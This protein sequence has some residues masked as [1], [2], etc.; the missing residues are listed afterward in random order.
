LMFEGGRYDFPRHLGPRG[1]QVFN[2][3]EI[4]RSQ[5]PDVDGNVVPVGITEGSAELMGAQGEVDSM[6]VA[7][8]AGIY[9]VKKGTCNYSCE[10]C[11]GVTDASVTPSSFAIALGSTTQLDFIETWST[12]QQF[13]G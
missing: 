11:T 10:T 8:D 9:N 6:L 7:M 13:H 1:T 2:I 3:S 12:G 5:V 4:V